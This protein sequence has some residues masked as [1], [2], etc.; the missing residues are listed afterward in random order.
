MT[1]LFAIPI[2]ITL[3]PSMKFATGSIPGISLECWIA[4][5]ITPILYPER[6]IVKIKPINAK[7][8][9]SFWK[10]EWKEGEENE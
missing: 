1:E 9:L 3:I 6:T 4:F 2:I 5:L 7:G 10:Y 8:K